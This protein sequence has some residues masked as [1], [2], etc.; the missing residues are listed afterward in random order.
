[1]PS[2]ILLP[3]ETLFF[4]FGLPKSGT[5]FLQRI[6]NQHPGISCPSEHQFNLLHDGIGSVLQNYNKALEVI[7]KR[8]GG[9]GASIIEAEVQLQVLRNTIE[10]I[11]KSAAGGKHIIGA[12]DNGIIKQL[13]QY[14]YL[15]ESPRFIAIFRNPLDMGVSSWHHNL[16][17]AEEENPKHREMMMQYGG[18]D[19]WLLQSARWYKEH[20]GV[21]RA[22]ADTHDNIMM[23][24]YEDLVLAA[25]SQM[26]RM[27]SFLGAGVTDDIITV[28]QTATDFRKMKQSSAQPGFFRAAATDFGAGRVDDKLRLQVVEIAGPELAWLGYDVIG[29]SLSEVRL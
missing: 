13:E 10:L 12:N 11:M 20:V 14:D 19:G 1:M 16:R 9:Q 3:D 4:C 26:Q 29:S 8:T 2:S 24:R 17:L 22:F 18:F 25:G 6:L 7:D 15:F 21:Y 5:T 28:I 27:F 23:I